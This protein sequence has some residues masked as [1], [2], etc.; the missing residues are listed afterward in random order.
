[1]MYVQSFSTL[2]M[3]M[4]TRGIDVGAYGKLI[5]INGVLIVL[6]QLPLTKWMKR[7][8]RGLFVCLAAVITGLGFGL[9]GLAQSAP[10][11]AMTI[12]IW[13]IG[14][15]MIAPYG[16]AIVTD[17]APVAYRARY[18]GVFTMCFASANMIG[19][20]L[21]GFVLAGGGGGMLWGG[22]LVLG[23][24][25]AILYATIYRQMSVKP[26]VDQTGQADR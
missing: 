15:I 20:P 19:A 24:I 7:Y 3:F 4:Q 11:F 17:M 21:G 1:M 25:A 13:T 5:A 23:F 16:F 6:L 18:L 2:P 26:A 12:A 9:T 10:F 8:N 22:T 14:E